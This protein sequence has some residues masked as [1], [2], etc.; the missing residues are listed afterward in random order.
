MDTLETKSDQVMVE[1]ANNTIDTW[2]SQLE[3]YSYRQL[4]TKPS[5]ESW[6]LGQLYAHL[7]SDANYYIEQISHCLSNN[8][9]EAEQ[10]SPAAQ[11]MFLANDFPDQL[12]EGA[13]GNA[14]IPQPK[15]KEELETALVNLKTELNSNWERIANTSFRGKTKHPGLNYFSA[16]EWF[17]FVDMHFRHHFRQKKRIDDYLKSIER[18]P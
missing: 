2:I 9:F 18:T 12:I 14:L 11:A 15:S 17:Q 3:H 6:S 4:C 16:R 13:P 8:D 5:P 7:I 10:A 1:A